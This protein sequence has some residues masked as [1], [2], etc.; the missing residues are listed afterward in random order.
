MSYRTP[1]QV[2]SFGRGAFV[3]VAQRG[4]VI[5]PVSLALDL[6]GP[7]SYQSHS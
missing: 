5:V 6:W 1:E 4:L 2:L 3:E 7:Y